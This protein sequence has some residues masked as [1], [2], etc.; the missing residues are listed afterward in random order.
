MRAGPITP[1][2]IVKNSQRAVSIR[3]P[4]LQRFAEVALDQARRSLRISSER[5]VG[6]EEISV[7]LVSDRRIALLHRRF[8]NIAGP[9]DVITFQHGEIFISTE[10]AVRQAKEY[11]STPADEIRLYI[12]HG[13]L[14]LL[15]FDDATDGTAKRMKKAQ[16]R[17][18]KAATAISRANY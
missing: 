11:A 2:V 6:I 15:G 3:L 12:V 5:L 18:F 4:E 17:I 13:I 1:G 14:H 10:T 8:M 16:D 7:I 9:T